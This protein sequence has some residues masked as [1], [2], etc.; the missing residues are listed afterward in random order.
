MN[1]FSDKLARIFGSPRFNLIAIGLIA[2]L[3]LIAYSNTFTASFHFDDDAAISENFAIKHVTVEN[4]LTCLN[5]N[6]P[7]VNLSL[8]LNYALGGLK[9]VGW[10][11]FNIGVHIA[12]SVLVFLFL[13]RTLNL[14]SL[15]ARYAEKSRRMALFGAL[16]F[17]V[18][19]IQTESV[20]YIISRSELLATFF[21]L[22]TFLFFIEGLQT[23]KFRH[24]V[25]AFF[26]SLLSMA[27]KEW[28]VTLPALLA[29]YDFLFVADGSLKNVLGRWKAYL[30]LVLPW[31]LILKIVMPSMSGSGGSTSA[32]F[33]ISG[34]KGITP[35]TYLLTS[36]NVMWTY[37]RLML[38]PI[39]QNLDY[40][41]PLAK[42][43]FEFPTLLSFL[44]H[45]A[46]VCGA[47]WLY[48]KKRSLLVPF[49]VAW[50]YI[51]L[52]PVQSFVPILDIIFEHRMYMPSIGFIMVFVV[53]YELFFD[54]VFE[55]KALK[56]AKA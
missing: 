46:V 30:L 26:T 33:G 14:P 40:D 25:L 17:A 19:P 56:E 42:T 53:G 48:L 50:F 41:Y 8:M 54:W 55:R 37:I 23:G 11:A 27:S 35:M 2:V 52:S 32:G 22:S 1:A 43:L 36:F 47:F 44:G 39:N 16:L 20:T 4:I 51:G 34:Q 3:V 45:V 29:L 38:L 21:Y 31:A 9:V 13:L 10:H 18:H 6:R 49:G 7:V 24:Y 12:N 5:S 28:A 15:S